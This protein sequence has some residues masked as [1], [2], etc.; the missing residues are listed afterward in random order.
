VRGLNEKVGAQQAIES[1]AER[2]A[3]DE[4]L[5]LVAVEVRGKPGSRQLRV[6]LDK[7]GGIGVLDLQQASQQIS[8]LL[9]VENPIEGHY[10]LEVSSPGLDRPLT[11]HADFLRAK[12]RLICLELREP[13]QGRSEWTGTLSEVTTDALTLDLDGRSFTFS[14]PL[15]ARA[16][17]EMALPRQ[18]KPSNDKRPRRAHA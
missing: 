11:T 7:Q 15:V 6:L 14:L 9:D 1:I 2:V 3:Q 8:A 5:I 17:M 4:G 13:S 18:P 12:G 10:T 16:R